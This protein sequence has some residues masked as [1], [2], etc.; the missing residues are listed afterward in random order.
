[1]LLRR[2]S[3]FGAENRA[4]EHEHR[5]WAEQRVWPQARVEG[6]ASRQRQTGQTSS[7]RR[8]SASMTPR[9]PGRLIS[10]TIAQISDRSRRDGRLI[11]PASHRSPIDLGETFHVRPARHGACPPPSS[12]GHT[13]NRL[14]CPSSRPPEHSPPWL[15]AVCGRK[16]ARRPLPSS[17]PSHRLYWPP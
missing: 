1:M 15:P 16:M 17:H 4:W 6:A 3:G 5:A 11:C 8:E 14:A 9:A 7:A 10:A 13:Q 12:P 2:T